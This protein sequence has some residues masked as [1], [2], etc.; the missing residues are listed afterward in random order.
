MPTATAVFPQSVKN[1]KTRVSNVDKTTLITDS[2]PDWA[3]GNFSGTWGISILGIPTIEL[4]GGLKDTSKSILLAALKGVF[5]EYDKSETAQICA[6]V[7]DYFF[8]GAV[9]SE[10][11]GN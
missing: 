2:P 7:I 1:L 4:G 9:G 11:T 6:L 8:L 10:T 3:T 5:A